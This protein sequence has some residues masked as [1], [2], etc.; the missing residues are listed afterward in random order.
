MLHLRAVA[1]SGSLAYLPRCIG[2]S[3]ARLQVAW[4]S[5]IAEKEFSSM[6]FDEGLHGRIACVEASPAQGRPKQIVAVLKLPRSLNS[7]D[8]E[9][10]RQEAEL[11]MSLADTAR[12]CIRQRVLTQAD[13]VK[14]CSCPRP[15]G[16]SCQTYTGR[17]C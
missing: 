17:R 8:I 10:H 13:C 6:R 3:V 2:S 9:E 1:C 12:C 7:A 14:V 16:E 5:W 11:H 4:G 15:C